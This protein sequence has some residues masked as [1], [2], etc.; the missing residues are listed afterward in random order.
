M[1]IGQVICALR[2]ERGLTQEEVALE[3]GTNAGYLSRIE[4]GERDPSLKMLQS[5]AAALGTDAPALFATLGTEQ[6]GAARLT[7]H[8]AQIA[9]DQATLRKV[10]T[11]LSPEHRKVLIGVGKLLA[12]AQSK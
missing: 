3:A 4:R 7:A 9:K 2:I 5:L 12:L 8:A 10:L 11:N 1:D 6:R